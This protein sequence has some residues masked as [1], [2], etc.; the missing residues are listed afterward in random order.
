MNNKY[1]IDE[2][3]CY[4]FEYSFDVKV[5]T[6]SLIISNDKYIDSDTYTARHFMDYF[7][8]SYNHVGKYLNC[9]PFTNPFQEPYNNF[10]P[11]PILNKMLKNALCA[12]TIERTKIYFE[13]ITLLLKNKEC[14]N[15]K[16]LKC[17]CEFMSVKMPECESDLIN[18]IPI[19]LYANQDNNHWF[20]Y[21]KENTKPIQRKHEPIIAEGNVGFDNVNIVYKI[22]SLADL[23]LASLYIL[24]NLNGTIKICRN[25]GKPFI[26]YNQKNRVYCSDNRSNCVQEGRKARERERYNNERNKLY[27][28]INMKLRYKANNITDTDSFIN[29]WEQLLFDFSDMYAEFKEKKISDDRIIK[30]LKDIDT[31]Y[32]KHKNAAFKLPDIEN[33]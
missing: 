8:F 23:W 31:Q 33:E 10:C 14:H 12:D 13:N 7:L 2:N 22:N 26:L 6:E 17:L 28:N 16:A 32:K 15:E 25:C 19:E 1:G 20:K 5:K 21:L 3:I 29:E 24:F 4:I 11:N 30:W 18:D 27:K 9:E